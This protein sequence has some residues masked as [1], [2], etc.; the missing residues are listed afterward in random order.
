MTLLLFSF[1]FNPSLGLEVTGM[2]DSLISQGVS[3]LTQQSM[4]GRDQS[5]SILVIVHIFFLP[6]RLWL[7][8]VTSYFIMY[9]K[10]VKQYSTNDANV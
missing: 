3:V 8:A 5:G 10:Y 1:R 4:D 9:V 7:F 2:A 6:F